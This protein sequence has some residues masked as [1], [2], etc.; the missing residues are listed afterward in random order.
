MD[1]APIESATTKVRI[2]LACSS[3]IKNFFI[4]VTFG[5][6]PRVAVLTVMVFLGHLQGAVTAAEQTPNW[7][8]VAERKPD[9]KVLVLIEGAK[10][11]DLPDLALLADRGLKPADRDPGLIVG[12]ERA[13]FACPIQQWLAARPL[14]DRMTA[15]LLSKFV[16]TGIYRVNFKVE[17]VGYVGPLT[18]EVTAPRDGFGRELAYADQLV[19]P[20]ARTSLRKD[21]AGNRWFSARYD[22]VRHGQT[23]R[24]HFAFKYLV[25]VTDLLDHALFMSEG[26]IVAGDLPEGVKPFLEPGYKIDPAL[27]QAVQW[28]S[29]GAAGPPDVRLE[30]KRLTELL[31]RSVKYDKHKRSEY[32][33]GRAV[34]SDLDA[35]YQQ[36]SV[37]LALRLGCCPDTVLL[38]CAFLRARGIPCRTAGRFGHFFTIVFVPGRGWMSTSATPTGIPLILAPGADHVPYQNW[39]PR[40]RLRTS[41]WEARVRIEPQE[42]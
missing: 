35:M 7:A 30:F 4:G 12:T 3:G 33:G 25:N 27:P 13:V 28:A 21:S 5:K 41:Q 42:E 8:L 38:E 14:P 11:F 37:T 1:E 36:A 40:I 10:P 18:L 29:T 2:I 24:F 19:R 6:I 22:E 26:P 20:K 9:F 39:K 34:Y 15:K 23:I 31:T 17:E 16:M 32:F